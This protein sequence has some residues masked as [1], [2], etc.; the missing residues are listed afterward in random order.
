MASK[1]IKRHFR[2]DGL[3]QPGKDQVK[4]WGWGKRAMWSGRTS[5]MLG[6][7]VTNYRIKDSTN[8]AY[9]PFIDICY[10]LIIWG[11]CCKCVYLYHI[12]GLVIKLWQGL[13]HLK[14]PLRWLLCTSNSESP[15]LSWIHDRSPSFPQEEEKSVKAAAG[16]TQKT[17]M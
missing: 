13:P 12:P 4:F 8:Y 10:F 11:A 15:W 16:Q 9:L 7:L 6:S 5:Q 17:E 3:G 2:N 1:K 14:K